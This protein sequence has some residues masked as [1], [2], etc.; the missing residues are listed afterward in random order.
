MIIERLIN[1]DNIMNASLVNI[2]GTPMV[3]FFVDES[4]F[5]SFIL[6]SILIFLYLDFVFLKLKIH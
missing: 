2:S 3:W 4:F 1:L 6:I 5:Y